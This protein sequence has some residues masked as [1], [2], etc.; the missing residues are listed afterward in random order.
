MGENEYYELTMPRTTHTPS[1]QKNERPGEYKKNNFAGEIRQKNVVIK[2]DCNGKRGI[3]TLGRKQKYPEHKEKAQALMNELLD[4]TVQVWTSEENPELK[5]I[6]EECE[7]SPAKLRKLLITAGERDGAVY[8]SSTTSDHILSLH[9]QGKSVAEIQEKMRL[10]YTSVQGY[11][12]HTQIYNL[13]TMSAECERIRL[14][15]K[16]KTAVTALQTHKGLPDESV[17]LW[18]CVVAFEGYVFST[19]GRGKDKTGSV[20]FKYNVSRS[21]GADGR[22]YDGEAVDGYGNE[23]FITSGGEQLKKSISRSTVDLALKR[24]REKE[25]GGPKA[26][27]LPG[28]GSYLYPILVRFGVVP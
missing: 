22:H 16:R 27:G 26:L 11:L 3:R 8:F 19:A 25:I 23:I 20:K 1:I 13:D 14:F 15:R 28:A 12:P 4:M 5:T 6:A 2:S 18:S 21:G 24:A 17:F 7:M 9:H 10:S